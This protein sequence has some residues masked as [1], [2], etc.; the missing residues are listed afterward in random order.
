MG[1]CPK[2]G[3]EKL[4]GNEKICLLCKCKNSEYISK[5][6]EEQLV[7]KRERDRQYATS[8]RIL[9]RQNGLC[10]KCCTRKSLVGKNMCGYCIEK[11]RV[12]YL[13]RKDI[14]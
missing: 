14:V 5:L 6:S 13:R 8:R 3:K 12:K 1:F 2:C 10:G 11:E 7:I 4:Y 9:A